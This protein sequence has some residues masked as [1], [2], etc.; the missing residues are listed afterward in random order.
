MYSFHSN[1]AH[2]SYGCQIHADQRFFSCF[3]M[4]TICWSADIWIRKDS[5]LFAIPENT[6]PKVNIT[7]RDIFIFFII[8]QLLHY[9]SK[10]IWV[11][12]RELVLVGVCLYFYFVCKVPYLICLS[13]LLKITH[14]QALFQIN[15][16][17][18][19]LKYEVR[20]SVP[21]YSCPFVFVLFFIPK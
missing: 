12:I 4:T 19:M 3:V 5:K 11:W 20:L 13:W 2:K 10:N 16:R 1:G 8:I 14:Y 7:D 18:A 6:I 17:K 9:I 21:F 15:F